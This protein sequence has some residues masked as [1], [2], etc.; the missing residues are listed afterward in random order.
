MTNVRDKLIIVGVIFIAIGDMALMAFKGFQGETI[1][2]DVLLLLGTAFNGRQ[3]SGSPVTDAALPPGSSVNPHQASPPHTGQ[4]A[5][6][7]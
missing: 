7:N 6:G 5:S 4:N 1:I 2:R 3:T